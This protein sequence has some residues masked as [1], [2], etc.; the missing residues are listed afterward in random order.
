MK[1]SF[2]ICVYFLPI[3]LIRIYKLISVIQIESMPP[4]LNRVNEPNLFRSFLIKKKY[5]FLYLFRHFLIKKKSNFLSID[6]FGPI[7]FYLHPLASRP[8]PPPKKKKGSPWIPHFRFSY[9]AR[10]S[11]KIGF[12][13]PA[14]ARGKQNSETLAI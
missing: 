13:M 7:L 4:C 1:F 12:L 6:V 11:G 14:A 10:K 9:K 3:S 8:P 2:F 5:I